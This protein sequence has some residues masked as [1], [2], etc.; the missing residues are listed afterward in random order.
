MN[1][2][3]QWVGTRSIRVPNNLPAK[4]GRGWNA[5]LPGSWSRYSAF[6]GGAFFLHLVA[7]DVRPRHPDSEKSQ[8]RLTSAATA[9]G[10]PCAIL[11]KLCGLSLAEWSYIGYDRRHIGPMAQ[12]FHA[13]FPWSGDE[14]TL[15]SADLDGVALAA[16]QG[17]NE[18]VESGERKAKAE[19][20]SLK[21][22][23]AELKQRLGRLEQLVAGRMGGER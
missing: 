6:R 20:E 2:P 8:S 7:A 12:D 10:S 16:I 11:D 9:Q 4:W 23:N 22:E 1:H 3:S 14:R 19:I 18:K 5:P 17:L 13:A 15:N 21:A